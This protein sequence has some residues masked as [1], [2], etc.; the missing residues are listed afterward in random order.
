MALETTWREVLDGVRLDGQTVVIT[1]GTTG[2]GLET[3]TALA[4]AG[5]HVVITAR[6][7]DKAR[8]AGPFD[9]VVLDLAD[10]DSVRAGASQ[11]GHVD[12]LVNNA[13][14]MYTPFERTAQGFELQLG[15]NHIGHFVLTDAVQPARVVNLSSGGHRA[16]DIHWDDPNYE[17]RPYDKFEAYGQSKTAN[18]LFTRELAKR[19]TH[20]L[21]VHP[22]MIITELGRYMTKD[23][24]QQLMGRVKAAPGG[25]PQYKSIEQGAA[26][27]V[28]AVAHP[29]LPS[30]AY[31]VDCEVSDE[32]AP[33]TR[34]ETAWA[35]LWDLT[36]ELVKS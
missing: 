18:I 11:L 4:S 23:D 30:G 3:A 31:L 33:W 12:V 1:G 24:L 7:E 20:A 9:H 16:S 25:A 21:A 13:G 14:V 8:A 6:S 28:W 19:G 22:G 27:T 29:E 5:A 2:L 34:D 35:R 10:L 26:T 17:Q 32:D 36:E 15:T